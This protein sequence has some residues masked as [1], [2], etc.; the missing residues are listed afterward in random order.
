M[1]KDNT[2][3]RIPSKIDCAYIAGLID[4]DGAIMAS[5]EQHLGKKF[6]FR[7]R[8]VIKITQKNPEILQ[9]IYKT[10]S[11]G[12]IAQNRSAID[13]VVKGQKEAEYIL[14]LI[15]GYL[16]GKRKQAQIALKILRLEVNCHDNLLRKAQLADAIGLLNVRSK[17]RR[18]NFASM[19]N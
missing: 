13:W 6:G 17:N 5:I 1:S 11:V 2:V 14:N 9:W 15:I 10:L 16:K 7:I 8:V 3:G 4:A 18:K 19:I 12:Y